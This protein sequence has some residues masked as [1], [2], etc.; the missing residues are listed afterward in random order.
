MKLNKKC[1]KNFFKNYKIKIQ[2]VYATHFI[3]QLQFMTTCQILNKKYA[4]HVVL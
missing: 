4:E 1:F 3:I 2:N